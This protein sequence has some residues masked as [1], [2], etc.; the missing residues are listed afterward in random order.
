M[1]LRRATVFA[2][3]LTLFMWVM[4]PA[5]SGVEPPA[6]ADAKWTLIYERNLSERQ[7]F[8]EWTPIL[9]EWEWSAEGLQ[10]QGGDNDV[11]IML[12]LPVVSGAV[13]IEHVARTERPGDLHLYTF[14]SARRIFLCIRRSQCAVQT[15]L[16]YEYK[17]GALGG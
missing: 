5:V 9:G 16:R 13:K 4:L 1:I 2:A 6:P 10:K 12:R 8:A 15:P 11:L 17:P 3:I 14:R 7:T